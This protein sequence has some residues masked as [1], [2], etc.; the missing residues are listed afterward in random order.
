MALAFESNMV[1]TNNVVTGWI[2]SLTSECLEWEIKVTR[3][4]ISF[5]EWRYLKLKGC[6]V[7][8]MLS[9]VKQR[10]Q[11]GR[12]KTATKSKQLSFS[13]DRQCIGA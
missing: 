12:R 2:A 4:T 5:E 13:L 8:V 1:L 11:R 3:Q 7:V 9:H 10:P 6:L